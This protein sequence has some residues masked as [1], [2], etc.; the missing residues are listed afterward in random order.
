MSGGVRNLRAMFENKD[1]SPPDRGRSPGESA[2]GAS[3]GTSPRPLSKVRTNFV[4]V[5]RNGQVGLGLR[6]ETSG[7]PS[8]AKRRESFSI[9]EEDHPKQTAE[10]K[11]SIATEMEARKNSTVISDTIPEMAVETPPPVESYKTLDGASS[12]APAKETPKADKAKA[13]DKKASSAGKTTNGHTN[14]TAK[15]TTAKTIEK[16]AATKHTPRPTPISTAKTTTAP[17]ASPKKSPLPKTPTTP[18]SRSHAQAKAPEKKVDKKVE[19]KIEKEPAKAP[20]PAQAKSASKPPTTAA[21]SASAKTRI[22]ASP[23]Q[24]GFVK[25]RPKSP[26]RPVKLPAS[27]TA[28]TASSGS[29]TAAA[30]APSRQSLSRASGNVQPTNSLQAHHALSRSP[31]RASATTTKSTTLTRKPSTLKSSTSSRPSLGPPPKEL[32]KQTSR[33]S[34]P[35]AADES[36]LARMMRPTTASSSKTAEKLHTTPPKRSQSVKRPSTR[37]GSSR[38]ATNLGSPAPKAR[39]ES[40][41]KTVAK[42]DKPVA[43]AS[44]EKVKEE[45]MAE[46]ASSVKADNAVLQKSPKKDVEVVQPAPEVEEATPV[47]PEISHVEETKHVEEF[48]PETVEEEPAAEELAEEKSSPIVEP[49]ETK[50]EI[51]A[52]EAIEPEK[53][54]TLAVEEPEV[55][56]EEATI[57]EAEPTEEEPVE[58]EPVKSEPVESE[59]VEPEPIVHQEVIKPAIIEDPE[60]VRA[61]EEIAKLN[62]EVMRAAEEAEGH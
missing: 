47:E 34:L 33:Q 12:S 20:A 39:K 51:P 48:I 31:S 19:K 26:T 36:F 21:S 35:A 40:P 54:A 9:D 32:K 10:R 55:T 22:P 44:P 29:K 13:E 60:D 15:P 30:P 14:G 59:P 1:P 61:R 37:D 23:P 42:D 45:P 27:L 4:T 58:S 56:K 62:A 57:S 52:A 25:P 5:E 43:K 24:T 17:K 53:E 46:I 49:T 16:A 11:Q 18:S 41:A 38:P 28:H 8:M 2:G 7:E 3:T 6:R 50:D